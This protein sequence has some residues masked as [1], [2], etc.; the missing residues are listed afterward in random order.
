MKH[1]YHFESINVWRET[2][3]TKAL[4]TDLDRIVQILNCDIATEEEQT[5]V[6]D[7]SRPEYPVLARALAARRDNLMDTIAALEHRLALTRKRASSQLP[8]SVPRPVAPDH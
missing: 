3:Q 6:S 5:G 2:A 4:I 8:S 7:R 1:Q